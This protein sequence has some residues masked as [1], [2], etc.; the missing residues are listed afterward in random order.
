MAHLTIPYTIIQ[1][2]DVTASRALNTVYTNTTGRTMFV[3]VSTGHSLINSGERSKA[4]GESPAVTKVQSIVGVF[5]TVINNIFYFETTL[6]VKPGDTY[7]IRSDLT[8]AAQLTIIAW[9]EAW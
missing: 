9:T 8:G 5:G 7:K 1:V 6:M 2:D 4:Y 3:T